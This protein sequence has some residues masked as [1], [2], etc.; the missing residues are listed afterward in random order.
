MFIGMS[1]TR[2]NLYWDAFFLMAG[3]L[4]WLIVYVVAIEVIQKCLASGP[5]EFEY[6]NGEII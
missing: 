4:T 1:I 3:W 2:M 6:A 5:N